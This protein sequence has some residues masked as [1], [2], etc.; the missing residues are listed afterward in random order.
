LNF[1]WNFPEFKQKVAEISSQIQNITVDNLI[2]NDKNYKYFGRLI[3][4]AIF[5]ALLSLTVVSIFYGKE[6]NR[7]KAIAINNEMLANKR[8]V[9]ILKTQTD[10]YLNGLGNIDSTNQDFKKIVSD[11]ST[12]EFV[13]SEIASWLKPSKDPSSL[14]GGKSAFV[15][16]KN[17]NVLYR[18]ILRN[19]LLKK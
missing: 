2:S 19:E 1:L 4:A 18:A 3:L 6:A 16:W 8:L 11:I 15:R 17:E 10:E 14:Q 5:F 7:Q 13:K 9:E 12:N